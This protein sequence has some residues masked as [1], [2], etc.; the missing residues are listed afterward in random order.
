MKS[1]KLT[2]CARVRAKNYNKIVLKKLQK[3]LAPSEKDDLPQNV[4][5]NYPIRIRYKIQFKHLSFVNLY[6]QIS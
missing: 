6:T 2:T 3:R 5:N 4:T 1:N